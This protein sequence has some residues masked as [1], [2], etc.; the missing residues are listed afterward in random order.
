MKIPVY[1]QQGKEAGQVL[2]PKEIFGLEMEPDLVYQVVV[3]E[4]GNRRQV[5]AKAKNR[6]EVSGGGR[7]PWRQ[8]GTGRARHGSIRSPLWKGGGVT[9]GP[10]TSRVFRK[11]INKKM[12]RKALLMLLSAKA[13][14]RL[15]LVLDSLNVEDPKTKL[16]FNIVQNLRA[17]LGTD[18]N[19]K[20]PENESLLFVLGKRD[21]NLLRASRNIP[22][23]KVITVN[24]LNNLDLIS[25][26][27]LVLPEQAIKTTQEI[28][29]KK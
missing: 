28:F 18:K 17:I 15:V 20:N 21:D 7:K 12:K 2:L 19:I 6:G 16:M 4:Q 14:E 22:G 1:N 10:T 26:K 25:F 8:K 13:K 23:V 5:S 27:Y 24:D 29:L 9:F 3:T 11:K